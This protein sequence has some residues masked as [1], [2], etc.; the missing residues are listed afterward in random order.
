MSLS[1]L[2][3]IGT[4]ISGIA[5]VVSLIYAALQFRVYA[6][7]AHENRYIGFT[8][9]IQQFRMAIATDPEIAR[10]YRDGLDD[11]DKLDSIDQWRFGAL[12]QALVQNFAIGMEFGDIN[13]PTDMQKNLAWILG[14]PG[15]RAWWPRAR[16]IFSDSVVAA[17][18][19]AQ[20][21]G[22]A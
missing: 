18:E 10:I 3:S 19:K 9:D 21:A 5:I 20:S 11:L 15:A 13:G 14:R 7:G 12:M 22:R 6:K 16:Q 17:V 2:A 8:N 1:D 4:F